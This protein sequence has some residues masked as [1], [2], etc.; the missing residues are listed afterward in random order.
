MACRRGRRGTVRAGRSGSV[1]LT[2]NIQLFAWARN[3]TDSWYFTY[4]T[5]S[6]TSAVAIAQAPDATATP[7]YGPAAPAT[8]YGGLRITF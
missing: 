8:F 6:P 4:C 7:S 5:F 3:V 1:Q 2:P